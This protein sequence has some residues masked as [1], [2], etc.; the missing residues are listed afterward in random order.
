MSD[1]PKSSATC[2][3]PLR[4]P[5]YD[6]DAMGVV[7]H[8]TYLR[9]F[10]NGRIEWL[11]AQGIRYVDCAAQGIHLVVVESQVRYLRAARFDDVL[12]VETILEE[13]RHATVLFRYRI[14]DS[15]EETL[16]AEGKTV[17]A[18]VG[19]DLRPKRFPANV[20]AALQGLPGGA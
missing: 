14:V 16:V 2:R 15:N 18:C 7:H 4:V 6:T 5:F 8:A 12:C 19:N 13:L 1:R 10:E 20:R 17:H 9:Y 11:R 3:T